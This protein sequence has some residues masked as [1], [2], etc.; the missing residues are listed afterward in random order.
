MSLLVGMFFVL[1][2]SLVIFGI[3]RKSNIAGVKFMLLG[4]NLIL[5]GGIIVVD[6]SLNLGEFAYIIILIGLSL[7]FVGFGKRN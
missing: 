4:L 5:V 7:S 1:M 2:V 6:D 3:L